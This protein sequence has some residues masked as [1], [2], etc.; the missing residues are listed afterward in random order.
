MWIKRV[1]VSLYRDMLVLQHDAASAL[2]VILN[3]DLNDAVST[4]ELLHVYVQLQTSVSLLLKTDKYETSVREMIHTNLQT[5]SLFTQSYL[6]GIV[7]RKY[8][9]QGWFFFDRIH[10]MPDEVVAL[11]FPELSKKELRVATQCAQ[12]ALPSDVAAE[13]I[14]AISSDEAMWQRGRSTN[15]DL[16]KQ[17]TEASSSSSD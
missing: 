8:L 16:L 7:R 13:A 2:Q 17:A 4:E 3:P 11:L 15:M 14:A 1:P 5:R 10:I 6:E 9:P 12:A